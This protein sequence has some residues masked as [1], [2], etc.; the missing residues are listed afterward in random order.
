MTNTEQTGR[1]GRVPV[2]IEPSRGRA[3]EVAGLAVPLPPVAR[4][5]MARGVI[6]NGG[7]GKRYDLDEP[8]PPRGFR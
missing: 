3:E 1:Y 5:P 8:G 7:D 4:P 2:G 6:H